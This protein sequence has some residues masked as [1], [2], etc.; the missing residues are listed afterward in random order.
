M[1]SFGVQHLIPSSVERI[2]RGLKPLL[3]L[4]QAPRGGHKPSVE[5]L[6]FQVFFRDECVVVR[7]VLLSGGGLMSS[8][9]GIAVIE[10]LLRLC[11]A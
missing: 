11:S 3:L 9:L 7:T 4:L 5:V 10:R 8:T 1:F 2:L 6:L